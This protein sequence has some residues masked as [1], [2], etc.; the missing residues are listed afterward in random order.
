VGAMLNTLVITHVAD[1]RFEVV[2]VVDGET[3]RSSPVEIAD[4]YDYRVDGE[5][6][7]RLM[8]ELG[9]YLEDFLDHPFDAN[10]DRAQRAE[11]KLKR[12]GTQAFEALFDTRQTGQ[13]YGAAVGAG[14]DQLHLRISSDDPAV[15]SWPWEALHDP[16]HGFL[17]LGCHIERR[18]NRDIADPRDLPESLST[19]RVNVL[20]V[21]ARPYDADVKYRSISRPLV[22]LVKDKHLPAE[23]TVLRPPTFEALEDYLKAR[24]GYYHI[25]HFDGHGGYGQAAP[26]AAGSA[27]QAGGG[28]GAAGQASP[29]QYAT[30]RGCLVF[31]DDR[32]K[33]R[34][35]W[36]D[37]L[38]QLLQDHCIPAVVLNACRS[39]MVVG[40]GDPF[41]S[42]AAALI[43]AGIR[44]VVAMAYSLYVS[45]AQQFLPAFY[46]DLFDE[47]DLAPATRAG[48]R[49]MYRK[50]ERVSMR[51]K[52]PLR[53]WLVPVVYQQQAMDFGFART[54][55]RTEGDASEGR[56]RLP[57]EITR[58][59]GKYGFI[60]RDRAILELERAMRRPP[61]GILIT[62]LGGVGKTTLAKGFAA[63]LADT[64]GLEAGCFWFDFRDVRSAEFVI[65]Q[66]GTP[67]YGERFRLV[68][69]LQQKID[70]LAKPLRRHAF[71]VVW[72]NFESASGVETAG[73]S[74]L[75][76]DE[77]RQA[78]GCLLERLRG[79]LTKVLITS[80]SDEP[81]L[82][83]TD[84]Y[85][86]PIGGLQG[87]ERWEF[88]EAI[89]DDLGLRP[90]REDKTL[91]ELMDELDGHPL[92]MQAVL[93]PLRELSAHRI[94]SAVRGNLE[95]LGSGADGAKEKVLATLG[96]VR[97]QIPADLQ[98]LLLPL[99]L[100]ERFVDAD[101]L[102]RM[103]QRADAGQTR[104]RID[105]LLS[106]LAPA[107]LIRV[108]GQAIYELHPA[109][110][111]YLRSALDQPEADRDTWARAYVDVMARL[112]D[113]LAPKQAHEQRI[114]FHVHGANFHFA[115]RE[116]ERLGMATDVAALT[117][118]L[119][120]YAQNTHN[121]EDAE[122]LFRRLAETREAAGDEVGMAVAYHQLGMIA[123]DLRDFD[124][125]Q[126]WYRKS[127]AIS[128]KL[129]NERGAAMTYHQLGIIAQLRR[130]F[131]QA[132]Q[133][134]RKSLAIKEKQGN[135]HGAAITYH[136]LGRVA[137]ERRDFDQAEQWYRKALAIKEKLGNEHGAAITYHQLGRIAEERRDFDQAQQWYLKSLAIKEK[138][139]NEHG[140]AITYHQLGM[141]A[142]LR[143]DFDQAQ[144]W[145]LKSLAIEE[146]QGNE[147]GAA[148]T[149]H[150]LGMIA[151]LRRDFDQAQQWYLKSLAIREKQGNEHGAASTYHQLGRIAEERRDFDQAQQWCRKAL[152]TFERL[153]DEHNAGIVRETLAR[154]AE[155]RG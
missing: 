38:C 149:Y 7:A 29:Y 125:A 28:Q 72:D 59:A 49:R 20:L 124:Q 85:R 153:R 155:Q 22:E 67:L 128:E 103:A 13:W 16:Q 6:D 93:P 119:A 114:A 104:E 154:I 66:M 131:D 95:S 74:A 1:G 84:C 34:E 122:R 112:T 146:K 82:P 21:V 56:S 94:L 63:W 4:P 32:G 99:S 96:F 142:Q 71:L 24:P 135:E 87:E 100:H 3:K 111:G 8:G 132:Q 9:W 89:L 133:W 127:L 61:A 134:Y 140:A 15:L 2:R 39:G 97:D 37:E 88:C 136:R 86:L 83:V 64:G 31:E 105:R 51:G 110:T 138:L 75:L 68:E 69:G 143:R 116:A 130:D 42:V 43:R 36:A 44:S 90:D 98:P 47:G 152:D 53:D 92:L 41:A 109:L 30:N 144:Q 57:A 5:S 12:W 81:W 106:A 101:Y 48:R 137:E 78:L 80:R 123:E 62:G 126:Q 55:P 117:Q 50:P 45:G 150:Q 79:G 26:P 10:I 40:A 25:L 35:V 115:L 70:L 18:L 46:S 73:V 23:V 14:L 121:Y 17:A 139:G 52:F 118:S 120:A 65:H 113:A 148:S 11:N 102:E 27:G 107:G 60:G 54:A 108:R 77:D 91:A 147:H 145:Y 141:I 151:Q 33:P 129:G 76:S 19:D 58:E